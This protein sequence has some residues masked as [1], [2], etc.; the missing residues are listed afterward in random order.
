MTTKSNSTGNYFDN[1]NFFHF[2]EKFYTFIYTL[3]SF[4]VNGV[5][6]LKAKYYG[7]GYTNPQCKTASRYDIPV[8]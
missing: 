7:E 4:M 3:R 5:I 6:N 1:F 8:V 2:K